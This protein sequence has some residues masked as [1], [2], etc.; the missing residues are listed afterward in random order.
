[1]LAFSRRLALA[2]I[3]C[4]ALFPALGL[5]SARP[6]A[7]STCS[8]ITGGT[9]VSS[10]ISDCS[11][12]LTI[13]QGVGG[14]FDVSVSYPTN[15]SSLTNNGFNNN[16]VLIGVVNDTSVT[17][18][19]LMLIGYSGSPIFNTVSSE[20]LCFTN[21]ASSAC[22]T[23]GANITHTATAPKNLATYTINGNEGT[24]LGNGNLVYFTSI[25]SGNATAL[26][27]GDVVFDGGLPVNYTA[28][29]AL[30]NLAAGAVCVTNAAGQCINTANEPASLFLFG[31]GL[32]AI[33]AT[34]RRWLAPRSR[35]R[36]LRW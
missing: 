12:I 33:V 19:D 21:L 10:T 28:E 36:W 18:Q 17:I 1:M 25:G 14:Q 24:I 22:G 3:A 30:T 7:A 26:N 32:L 16:G 2:L 31:S 29:F 13:T 27:E 20:T 15:G 23:N 5:L 34:R 35:G 11:E 6:A 4:A 8:A 9:G